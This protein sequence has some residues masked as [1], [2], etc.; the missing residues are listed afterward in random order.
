MGYDD[1]I[2]RAGQKTPPGV[3]VMR[4]AMM[5]RDAMRKPG[6]AGK[7]SS[8]ADLLNDGRLVDRAARGGKWD[9]PR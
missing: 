1:E 5:A 6:N 8:A 7:P 3:C 9:E 2:K 4:M